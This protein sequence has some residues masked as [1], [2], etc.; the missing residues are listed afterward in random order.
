MIF[1]KP[2]AV[3]IYSYKIAN[4]RIFNKLLRLVCIPV[5]FIF[6][7]DHSARADETTDFQFNTDFLVGKNGTPLDL[8]RFERGESFEAGEYKLDVYVNQVPVDNLSIKLTNEKVI[9]FTL[10]QIRKLGID[11][12]KIPNSDS[13]ENALKRENEIDITGLIP[14]STVEFNAAALRINLSIPQAYLTTVDRNYVSPANIDTGVKATFVDYNASAWNSNVAGM[15]K[16]QY[17]AGFNAGANLS[18][19]RLRHSG[20][21]TQNSSGDAKY[22]AINTYAQRDI[23]VLKSQLTLGQYYSPSELFDSVAYSGVQLA[24]DDRMLP[25]SL[26]GYAPTVRGIAQTN[27]KVTVRQGNNILLET[28]VAPGPFAIDGLSGSGYA[29]DLSVTV[30]EADGQIRSFIVPFATVAQLLR[31]GVSRYSIVVGKYRDDSINDTPEFLQA[32]YQKGLNNLLTGY[33]GTIIAKNYQSFLGGMGVST[34]F[35]AFAVDVTHSKTSNLQARSSQDNNISGQSYRIGYSKLVESTQTNFTLAAYRFSSEGY[36]TLSDYAQYNGINEQ[37]FSSYR[38]RSRF[39]SNISQTLG[40]GLGSVYLSGS[41]QNYWHDNNSND[42]NYQA[43]YNNSFRWGSL[44]VA[45][46]RS[47]S[48]YGGSDTQYRVGVSIPLGSRFHSPFLTSAVTHS[49]SGWNSQVGLSG[50]AGKQNQ[51]NYNVYGNRNQIGND[52]ALSGGGNVQYRTS[53]AEFAANIS[54]GD[55]YR[56][57]G[58]GMSG[59]IVAHPGG[60]N[61]SQAQGETKAIIAARGA[62]GASLTNSNGAKVDSNGYA[63]VSGLT[64]YRENTLS[65]DPKGIPDDVEL[66]VTQQNV[67]P[68]YGAVVMLDYPTVS[69]QPILL[70]LRDDEGQQLP[71]GAEVFNAVNESL[72]L[73]GQGS[74]V[75]LRVQESR[76]KIKVKWGESIDRQCVAEYSLPASVD[77]KTSFLRL[78]AVC[79]RN[80]NG[81]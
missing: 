53:Q 6:G 55:Q 64:P 33:T 49:Q 12:E 2:K 68:G 48:Q 41:V 28:S 13:K 19:W 35:G 50:A 71:V 79:H 9:Y 10:T 52:V 15:P 51:L 14:T 36:M 67:A 66:S 75:F 69:G 8:S 80:L 5:M 42:I 31:P 57:V 4:S 65:I 20:N 45:V 40:E 22:T 76:G 58:L 26:R 60:I 77:M 21:Y 34:S 43:G 39:Q 25:D 11:I 72:T 37:N 32:T 24:F 81:I 47:H 1:T 62:K 7:V 73:V 16:A 46:N 59:S 30:T 17:Y 63:I 70:Q 38:Q 54:K 74:R 56:Q 27:A 3:T 78:S 18:E 61:F 23:S 29:G 44:S